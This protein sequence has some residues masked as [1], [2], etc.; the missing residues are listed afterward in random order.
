MSLYIIDLLRAMLWLLP[1]YCLGRVFVVWRRKV[2]KDHSLHVRREVAL[3]IFTLFM[4]GLLTLTFENGYEWMRS[5]SLAEAI[6][7]FRGNVGVNKI[8]FHTIR[9]YLKH[10]SNVQY[11]WINVIGNIVMFIPWGF[12][13][14]LLWEKYQSAFK[15]AF[16]SLMLPI[17][18]EFFQ[19][20][21]GRSVDVDDVILNFIGGVLGGL[22]Y[23]IGQKLF[24]GI[25]QLAWKQEQVE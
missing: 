11:L 9:I 16:M 14:P 18:I 10:A 5:R 4:V 15:V 20:F 13:L 21:V 1:V 17:L 24:P 3:A 8:P 25:K 19:L 7:R 22:L 2:V 6:M 23:L 12:G